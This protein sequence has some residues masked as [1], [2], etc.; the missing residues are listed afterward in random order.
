MGVSDNYSVRETAGTLSGTEI[1]PAWKDGKNVRTTTQAIA[2]LAAPSAE[3]NGVEFDGSTNIT[4][5][6]IGNVTFPAAQ[7]PSTDAN[8]LDDYEE[9]TFSLSAFFF[10]GTAAGITYG[11]RTGFYTKI[12][13]LVHVTGLLTLTSKGTDSGN[14]RI[15]DLPFPVLNVNY[16]NAA[17]TIWADKV[18]FTGQLQGYAEKGSTG[19]VVQQLTEAG[20]VSSLTDANIANDS[21]FFINVTY[22]T[23]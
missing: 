17:V 11:Q 18:T 12:G 19:I 20:V 21:S 9:G 22:M 2:D 13:R 10:G 23:E 1:I 15:L 16:A 14:F 7:I 4:V 5:P 3:I 6:G 8:T